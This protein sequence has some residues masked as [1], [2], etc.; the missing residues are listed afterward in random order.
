MYNNRT[1][2]NLLQ[3]LA[4]DDQ[5]AFTELYRRY[6]KPLYITAYGILQERSV[7]EDV[8]QDVFS[9]L[10]RRRRELSI[11]SPKAY[12]QQAT[13]FRVFKAISTGKTDANFQ[14]RLTE[15]SRD[16]IAESPLMAK[17]LQQLLQ[18]LIGSLPDDQQMILRLSREEDLTYK[19]I[20]FKLGISV[21]TV[22]KKISRS[23]RHIRSGLNDSYL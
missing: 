1:D 17:E 13:R 18:K 19:D 21:K 16:M 8:V 5:A 11:R 4:G 3:M 15:V 7:A 9:S 2:I 23:L 22:E 6:W 10:W 14:E 12:L 20:A